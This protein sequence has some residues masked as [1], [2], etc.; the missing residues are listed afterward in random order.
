M[1]LYYDMVSFKMVQWDKKIKPRYFKKRT[2]HF[3]ALR[4]TVD[5]TT[6]FKP[7]MVALGDFSKYYAIENRFDRLDQTA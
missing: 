3:L 1:A 5:I 4:W 2:V 6:I 7:F